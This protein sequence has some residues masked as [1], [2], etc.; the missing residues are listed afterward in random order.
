MLQSCFLAI[1]NEYKVVASLITLDVTNT[2]LD[3]IA[4]SALSKSFSLN[5]KVAPKLTTIALLP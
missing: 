5:S 3:F 1:F 4:S 2:L